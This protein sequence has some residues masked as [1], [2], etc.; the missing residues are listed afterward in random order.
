MGWI[1]SNSKGFNEALQKGIK[2]GLTKIGMKAETYAKQL[3]PTDTGLLRNS[4][5]YAIGGEQP[6]IRKYYDDAG[7]NSGKYAGVAP[8][9]ST[10]Q[11]TLYIGSNVNY[12]PF[13]EL[14][15]HTT[16]GTWI[17]PQEFIGPSIEGHRTEYQNILKAEVENALR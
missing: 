15:H 6:H 2:N 8:A 14:G 5:T 3:A 7:A 12:A 4:V 16:K 1:E 10:G 11:T 17:E 9:D 13:Q